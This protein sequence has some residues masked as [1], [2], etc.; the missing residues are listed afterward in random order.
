MSATARI[1]IYI[2]LIIKILF[3]ILILKDTK[4]LN[5]LFD[6]QILGLVKYI[7]ETIPLPIVLQSHTLRNVFYVPT[8]TMLLILPFNLHKI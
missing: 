7:N 3:R 4:T 1:Y 2:I 5:Y 8:R 6:S